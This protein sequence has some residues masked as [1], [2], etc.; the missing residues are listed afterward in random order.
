[1]DGGAARLHALGLIPHLVTGDFDSLSGE[2]KEALAAAGAQIVPTPDQNYTDLD[3][4]LGYSIEVL[5][6]CT[7]YVFGA[8]GGRLDHTYS[9]LSAVLK[10]GRRADVRLVDEVG[11]TWLL[12]GEATLNGPG[13]A[14]RILSLMAFG[15]VTDIRT[16]GLRWPLHAN[17]SLRV[18]AT[19]R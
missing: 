17:R 2:A 9:A 18:S 1:M 16:E 14:G 5:G 11:E 19:V 10:Y 13:L 6:A 12:H 4:A 3:K 8:T 15:V 7:I